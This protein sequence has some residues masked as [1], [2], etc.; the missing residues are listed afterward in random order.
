MDPLMDSII[1]SFVKGHEMG[2]TADSISIHLLRCLVRNS[3][4][5]P[6]QL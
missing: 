3:F 4:V 2:W 5:V 6:K 1:L